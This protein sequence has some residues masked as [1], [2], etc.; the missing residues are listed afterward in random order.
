MG[1]FNRWK[2]EGDEEEHAE[3]V[4][5][6]DALEEKTKELTRILRRLEIDTEVS[7]Q[8]MKR[9]TWRAQ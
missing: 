3:V 5:K 6:L 4:A 2:N 1:L 9:Q 7:M 8:K